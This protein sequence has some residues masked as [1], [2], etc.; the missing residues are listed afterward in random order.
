MNSRSSS[1]VLRRAML[2]A[3]SDQMKPQMPGQRCVIPLQELVM[4]PR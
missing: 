3:L 1:R 2:L 4:T